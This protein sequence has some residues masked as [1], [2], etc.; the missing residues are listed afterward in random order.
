MADSI[1][2]LALGLQYSLILLI[3]NMFFR[4]PLSFAA[5]TIAFL[6][7]AVIGLA[8]WHRKSPPQTVKQWA[9]FAAGSVVLGIAFFGV[10]LLL[11][12]LNGHTNPL[13]F[14]GGLLGLPLTILVCPVATIICLAG[15]VRAF[16][17]SQTAAATQ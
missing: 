8:L 10:D 2:I 4:V 17:I 5:A 14:P 13:D 16:Y 1:A 3:I 11:A 7:L 12:Y 6:A 9:N 15:L